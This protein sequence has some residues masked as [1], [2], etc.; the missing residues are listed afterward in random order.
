MIALLGSIVLGITLAALMNWLSTYFFE[1][2]KYYEEEQKS[3]TEEEKNKEKKKELSPFGR[4]VVA[5]VVFTV[6]NFMTI[7]IPAGLAIIL[8]LVPILGMVYLFLWWNEEGSTIKEALVFMLINLIVSVPLRGAAARIRDLTTIRWIIALFE[9]LAS[10]ALI[11]LIGF[12]VADI[13]WWNT[14]S[15][16]GKLNLFKKFWKGGKSDE[17]RSEGRSK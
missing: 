2:D 9:S 16:G 10:I 3:K 13:V 6:V 5:G 17:V 7:K 11:L 15:N 12:L 14:S 4:A 8:V 1:E